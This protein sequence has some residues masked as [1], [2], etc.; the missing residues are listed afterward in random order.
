[1]SVFHCAFRVSVIVACLFLTISVSVPA[2]AQVNSSLA[3]TVEDARKAL[4]PGVTITATNIQTG[5][6][7]RTLTNDTGSYT[8]PAL[9]PGSY[10]I[11]AE[12]AGFNSKTVSSIDLGGGLSFRQN[13]VLDIA[14]TGTSVDVEIAADS[15][16]AAS[17]ASIGEVL[18]SSR[19]ANLPVVGNNVLDLVRIL[20]GYRESALGAAFDTFAG[21]SA[22]SVNTTRDGISVTDGRFVNGVFSTTTINPDLVGEVRLILT[23]VD[24]EQGRGNAQ[25]QIQTRSGTNAFTGSAAWYIRNTALDPNS[26]TGNRT[27]TTP[28]WSN[29]HEYSIA[30]GGPI[31]KSKTFFY[32]LW[33]QQIHRERTQVDGAVLTDTARQGIFRYFDGWNPTTYDTAAT[34]TPSSST[35]R[36]AP[37]VDPFGQPTP[38]QFNAAGTNVPYSGAGLLCW[39]VFGNQRLNLNTGGMV[40]FTAADCP[41]GAIISSPG[42]SWD[43]NRPAIDGTG[44]IF[45]ALLKNM[46]HANFFGRT[47]TVPDGLNTATHRWLRGTAGNAG[48]QTTQGTGEFNDRKQI[49]IKLDH[50]FSSSHKLSGSY[51]LE[52]NAAASGL[53]NWPGGYGGTID[54]NPHVLATNLTST[55]SSS[56]VNEARF[57]LRFN[58]THG[59]MAFEVHKDELQDVLSLISGGPDPGYTRA[60]GTTYPALFNAGVPNPSIFVA[61]P[62]NFSGANSYFNNAG[63]HNG[64]RSILYTYGDTVS[65]NMGK[66]AFKFGGEYRPTTSKG[67]SNVPAFSY[68]IVQGGSGPNIAPIAAGGTSV[69]GVGGSNLLD[70]S[71][72]NAANL[73]YTL[74]GSVDSVNLLYWMDSFADVNDGKWQSIATKPDIY[75]TIIINEGSFFA[76][77][78]WKLTRN[79]TLNLGLRWEYYA[80]PYIQEGFTTTPHD[81]GLGLFGVGRSTTPGV[82]DNWLTPSPNPIYLSG[83][84]NAASAANALQCTTGVAQTN[85]P[86][87][88]CNAGLMTVMDF[89]GPDSP[90]PTQSAIKNDL[91]NFGPAVGFAWQVPWFGEGK[92]S[93]RGGYQRT[94]GGAGRNTSTIG[95]GSSAVLGSVPG[96]TSIISGQATLSSQVPSAVP[97]TIA[98]IPRIVPLAPTSPAVPGGTLPIYTRNATTI[99]GYAPDYVTPYTENYTLSMTTN[100]SRALTV[101]IRYVGTQ[102]RKQEADINLNLANVYNNKELFDALAAARVGD[103]SGANGLLLTQLLAGLNLNGGVAGYGTVGSV[104]NGVYQTGGMHLRRSSTYNTNLINGNFLAIA[105]SL[106]TTTTPTGF[107]ATTQLPTNPSGRVIRNGCDRIATS[108]SPNF[109]VGAGPVIPLRCFPENYLFPNPQLNVANYRTNTASSNYHSMQAQATVRPISGVSIQTTYTWS[110][111]LGTAGSGNADPLNRQADYSK[112]FSSLTHDWR[113]NGTVELPIGPNK[114]LMGNSSGWLARVVE[115]W[116][117]SLIFNA[118]SGRPD[119]ITAGT[120]NYA[121]TAAPD[122]VGPWDA[123][124]GSMQWDGTKNQGFY[125]GNPSSYL[126]VPDP[127]CSLTRSVTDATGFNLGSVNCG[128]NA[129]AKA[130]DPG[131]P[132][133]VVVPG[134]GTV[135]YLLVN[136]QPGTQGTLGLATMESLGIYRFDANIAKSFRIDEKKSVQIRVDALNVLNHPQIGTPT[137]SINSPNFGLVTTDKTGGRSLQGSLR[138]SF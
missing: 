27:G 37:A 54:R 52:R 136:P 19:V 132:G 26:W 23:P 18:T 94:F 63:S 83:Y 53:S 29:N 133:A 112:P 126:V 28:N 129:I 85:L 87:S 36:V 125:F 59:L 62:Y 45:N 91:N 65:W 4:I 40:P 8:I 75:R 38:P 66:H 44:Y 114:L 135:Q 118:S 128:L 35:A 106:A 130:V 41:G 77:D 2:V 76:K 116:Q 122:I 82:F 56:L 81:L 31:I 71:R 72:N 14:T 12:L 50:N 58:D 43:P 1:M 25:I 121:A 123:R 79:F 90:N 119:S 131:T 11:K 67:Y 96:N 13:F 134:V 6:E 48:I 17:S 93:L 70:T 10:R 117:T 33:D 3:G 109:S 100:V 64:N 69:I 55:L 124:S 61:S 15:L 49:N 42:A 20:P 107:V 30:Y 5:V 110:K 92:T 138:F 105:N 111:T 68:P 127:Q 7:N 95:G 39:S 103:D 97:L 101:D 113:T 21:T 78:D 86:A 102:S 16:L 89:I 22:A 137:Y 115:R 84:G 57:G 24:A 108:G 51:T 9:I 32:V 104:V 73:L 47:A 46:P 98:D 88:S 99:Y 34:T 80:S 60:V 120:L 74:S